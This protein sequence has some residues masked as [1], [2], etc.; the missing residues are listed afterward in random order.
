MR[1]ASTPWSASFTA[2]WPRA[3]AA[4][5]AKAPSST[6]QFS[7]KHRCTNP[8][9]APERL[10]SAVSALG[11][12]LELGCWSLEFFPANALG[13]LHVPRPLVAARAA[14]PAAAY[15]GAR[16]ARRGGAGRTF[17]RRVAP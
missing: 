10:L 2:A 6:L 7:K 9:K 11:Y 15:L 3:N 4:D 8:S 12:S 17:R 13:R 1:N 5:A 16:P 14:H